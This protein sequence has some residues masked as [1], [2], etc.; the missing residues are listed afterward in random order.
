M[1]AKKAR[2][3]INNEKQDPF[4]FVSVWLWVSR[5]CINPYILSTKHDLPFL[6]F[7]SKFE[8]WKGRHLASLRHRA[9]GWRIQLVM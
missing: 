7:V 4:Q 5:C 8:G 1:K 9:T 6:I 3:I 2:L